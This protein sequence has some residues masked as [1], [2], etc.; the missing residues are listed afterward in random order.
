MAPWPVRVKFPAI[1]YVSC[2]SETITQTSGMIILLWLIVLVHL[3]ESFLCRF[4]PCLWNVLGLR[5]LLDHKGLAGPAIYRFPGTRTPR[6][7][8]GCPPLPSR[9]PFS[10]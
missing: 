5:F 10:L 4:P 1:R 8:T 7:R 9:R 3:S 6:S 2:E